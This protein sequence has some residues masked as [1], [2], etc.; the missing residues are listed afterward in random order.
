MEQNQSY[1]ASEKVGKLIFTKLLF[2]EA[3]FGTD[4][5]VNAVNEVEM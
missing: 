1:L 5:A 2:A 4:F 3:C